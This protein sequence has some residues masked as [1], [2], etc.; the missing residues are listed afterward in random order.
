MSIWC[1]KVYWGVWRVNGGTCVIPLKNFSEKNEHI[2]LN[3]R[4]TYALLQPWQ[5]ENLAG[6]SFFMRIL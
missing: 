2:N 1:T 3:T 6:G 4:K 5:L